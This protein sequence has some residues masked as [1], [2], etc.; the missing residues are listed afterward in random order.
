[1]KKR[2]W[3]EYLWIFSV[4]YLVLGFFNILFAWLGLVCFNT[5]LA[6]AVI[7]GNKSY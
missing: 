4:L 7:K 5:P 2:R 1:M 6:I 3:H